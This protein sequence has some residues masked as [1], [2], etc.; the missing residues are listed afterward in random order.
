[1]SI[2]HRSLFKVFLLASLAIVL[3]C[4][5]EMPY[6]VFNGSHD[7]LVH[8][9][10][11]PIGMALLMVLTLISALVDRSKGQKVSIFRCGLYMTMVAILVIIVSFFTWLMNVGF[12]N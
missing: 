6:N 3:L 4:L 2:D 12:T 8:F 11:I 7:V 10:L 1:M 9:A 5:L